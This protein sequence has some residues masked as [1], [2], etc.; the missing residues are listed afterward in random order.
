MA[1]IPQL[2]W[3]LFY[4]AFFQKKDSRKMADCSDEECC[5]C[6]EVN[7]TLCRVSPPHG[8]QLINYSVTFLAALSSS[9]SPV[10]PVLMG[11]CTWKIR[12]G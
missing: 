11:S 1:F 8:K 9:R 12:E 6:R 3:G 4:A 5:V 7:C 10:G 2:C